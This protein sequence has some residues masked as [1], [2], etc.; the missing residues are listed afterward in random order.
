[1][2][3]RLVSRILL[4]ED[5]RDHLALFTMVLQGAGY[6]VDGFSDPVV[7][8]SKFKPNS[9]DLVVLDYRMPKLNGLE[10]YKRII[11][12]GQETKALLITATHEQITDD[13]GEQL[14]N[15][16]NVRIIRKPVSN[17]DLLKEIRSLLKIGK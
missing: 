5:D 14:Q 15:Q 8:L 9:H 12:L 11:E 7:A 13:D 17:E 3:I 2:S 4:V 1:L 6:S 16:A 10:L